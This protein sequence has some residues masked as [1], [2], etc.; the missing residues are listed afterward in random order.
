M[1]KPNRQDK[2]A[3]GFYQLVEQQK[4]VYNLGTR[5]LDPELIEVIYKPGGK[6]HWAGNATLWSSCGSVRPLEADG[7]ARTLLRITDIPADMQCKNCA[8]SLRQDASS[9]RSRTETDEE[10]LTQLRAIMEGWGMKPPQEFKLTN[11]P[12]R[13]T[14]APSGLPLAKRIDLLYQIWSL[15]ADDKAL[16]PSLVG[17]WQSFQQETKLSPEMMSAYFTALAREEAWHRV[18]QFL[19]ESYSHLWPVAGGLRKGASFTELRKQDTVDLPAVTWDYLQTFDEPV[20]LDTPL[21]LWVGRPDFGPTRV[22]KLEGLYRSDPGSWHG[23]YLAIPYVFN[24]T[25]TYLSQLPLTLRDISDAVWA[26]EQAGELVTTGAI[27]DP[28][29]A[30]NALL[31]AV[32]LPVA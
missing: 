32:T 14:Q 5:T 31:T 18:K 26:V 10:K 20:P 27:L 15:K 29:E 25:G 7:A 3:D 4:R 1:R 12:A 17:L 9:Q 23:L 13:A 24:G 8:M 19:Q 2:P 22:A 16:P 21:E 28:R 11:L 6:Y 30:V